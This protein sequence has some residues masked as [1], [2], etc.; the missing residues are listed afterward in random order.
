MT[1]SPRNRVTRLLAPVVGSKD[2]LNTVTILAG[3]PP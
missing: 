3:L 1:V 2:L